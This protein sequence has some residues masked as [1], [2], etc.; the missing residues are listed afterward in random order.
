M[1]TRRLIIAGLLALPLAGCG[2]D[3]PK[4]SWVGVYDKEDRIEIL[5]GGRARVTALRGKPL[6][7]WIKT[8]PALTDLGRQFDEAERALAQFE[9]VE[10]RYSVDGATVTFTSETRGSR[11]LKRGGD[12]MLID[13]SSALRDYLWQKR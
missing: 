13:E 5:G 6:D 1:P 4:G 3:L 11:V 9:Q 8:A 10:V 7:A 12:D 2:E